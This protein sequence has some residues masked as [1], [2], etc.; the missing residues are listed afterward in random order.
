MRRLAER[1]PKLAA[2]VRPRQPRGAGQVVDVQ[3][4]DV[5]SVGEVSGA[6][7]VAGR[8]NEVHGFSIVTLAGSRDRLRASC[9]S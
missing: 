1:S 9:R 8:R 4:F 3:R 5:A 6:Q 7:Q 2:E